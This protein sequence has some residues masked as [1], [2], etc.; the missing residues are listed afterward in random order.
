M[1]FH[2]IINI[3]LLTKVF[4]DDDAEMDLSVCLSV[5]VDV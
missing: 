5:I 2:L 4:D 1:D 3:R